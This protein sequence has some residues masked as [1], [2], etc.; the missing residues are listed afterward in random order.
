MISRV[1]IANKK[2]YINSYLHLII[3]KI[4]IMKISKI[5]KITIII[6][7]KINKFTTMINI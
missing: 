1:L 6:I 7:F 2:K 4:T 5:N 3:N